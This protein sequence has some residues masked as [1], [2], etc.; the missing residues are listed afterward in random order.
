MKRSR[1]LV[2]VIFMTLFV[3][4]ATLSVHAANNG[5][6]EGAGVI[7][8]GPLIKKGP[9]AKVGLDLANLHKEYKAHVD[10]EGGDEGF[11]PSNPLMPVVGNR[12]AIDAVAVDGA[13]P[14]KGDL[15]GRPFD[16][17]ESNMVPPQAVIHATLW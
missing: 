3:V 17:V 1:L 10:K 12:V 6:G 2:L 8:R 15:K 9:M 5:A 16:F 13:E 14:L 4:G 11:K 7:V